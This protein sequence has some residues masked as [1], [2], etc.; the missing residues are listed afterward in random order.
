MVS[1]CTFTCVRDCDRDV[2]DTAHIL[3]VR[4]LTWDSS[5]CVNDTAR[6]INVFEGLTQ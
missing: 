6:S 1:Y 3:C 5:Q 2:N 4:G